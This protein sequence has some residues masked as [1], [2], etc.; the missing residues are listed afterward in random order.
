VKYGVKLSEIQVKT[1]QESYLILRNVDFV[2]KYFPFFLQT[3]LRSTFK[4]EINHSKNLNFIFNNLSKRRHSVSPEEKEVERMLNEQM[5]PRVLDTL[6]F[7]N[8]SAITE[9]RNTQI[10]SSVCHN[11]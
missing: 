9:L 3:S 2:A 7:N 8:S 10:E 6:S 4:L 5:S 1:M 11:S